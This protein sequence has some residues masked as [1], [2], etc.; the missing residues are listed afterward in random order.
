MKKQ[1]RFIL[2]LLLCLSLAVLLMPPRAEAAGLELTFPNG[3][4][5]LYKGQT[6]NI[7]WEG[8]P[9]KVFTVYLSTDSGATF[10]EIGLGSDG[11]FAW[12]VPSDI[13][14]TNQA[15]IKIHGIVDYIRIG[16]G[17]PLQP[18][19]AEDVSDEDFN[20]TYFTLTPTD[21]IPRPSPIDPSLFIPAAPSN[22]TAA[23]A[24]QLE[25]LTVTSIQLTWVDN[26]T[27]EKGFKVER[28]PEGGT[29][30][31]VG[32]VGENETGF[33]DQN[34]FS[35]DTTYYYR[36]YAYNDIGDSPYSNVTGL[37]TPPLA[38]DPP[39]DPPLSV[40]EA[41]SNLEAVALSSSEIKLTWAD[42]ANNEDGFRVE[43]NGTVIASVGANVQTF[44]DSGLTAATSYTYKIKAFNDE[45]ISAYSNEASATTLSA[46]MPP[47]QPAEPTT[48]L[49]YIDST[50][51][52]VN[53]V[54][55]DMDTAPIIRE[56]RTMLPIRYVAEPLGALMIWESDERKVT[57]SL[58]NTV[59]EVWI[60]NNQGRVNGVYQYIDE[61]NHHVMP[62]IAPPGRTMLP[63]RFIAESLGCQVEWDGELREV[64]ITYPS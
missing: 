27:V 2:L 11:S 46:E 35:P 31:L 21:P 28:Q 61:T 34:S 23:V 1:G 48:M 49:F 13:P 29:W 36:V 56:G 38:P 53:G 16:F 55:K 59:V 47:A 43:R 37:T 26:S 25:N 62:F 44:T 22:L 20:I 19:Y 5:T 58:D 7:T 8:Y 12:Q 42:N 39:A 60:G 50:E 51:Y 63:L 57:L 64:K 41:P 24:S 14:A 30:S 3:G 45:G 9:D 15:R 40:P 52:Y 54:L 4:E 10:E 6:Y 32:E 18:I 33:L 17:V